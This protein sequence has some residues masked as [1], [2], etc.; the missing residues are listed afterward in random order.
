MSSLSARA[1]VERSGFRDLK[2]VAK[3]RESAIITSFLLEPVQAQGWRP[4][5]PGQFLV[6][7]IPAS[8]QAAGAKDYVLRN[9][10]VS[11]P[12]SVVGTYRISVKREAP[13]KAGLPAGLSSCFL[14]DQIEVGDVL[15]AEGPRGDFVLDSGSSRPVVLLSGGVGLTPMVSMLHAL[16]STPDPSISDRRVVFIHA[17]ENGDVHALRDEV[18][19]LA[20]T[21][22]GVTVHFCYRSPTERDKSDRKFHSEGLVSREMLQRLL[23]LDDYDFYL[24]G[25]PPFMQAVYAIVR[26][27]GVPKARVAY[28]FF[29]PATVLDVAQTPAIAPPRVEIEPDGKAVAVEFRKS[30]IKAAWDGVSSLLEF[31]EEQGLEPEFSCRAGVCGT[32]KSRLISGEVS[33]FEEPLDELEPGEVLLCCSKPRGSVVLDI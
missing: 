21:R 17:C 10:S 31:A 4:Y 16:S 28:E 7:R 23:P 5:Q 15:S 9:Y 14:H 13:P 22:P 25:P 1:S 11:G 6:F 18:S 30:G 24:C 19:A 2:V 26:D 29:G 20:A 8:K 33:Y 3:V 12:P 27:L 32:C